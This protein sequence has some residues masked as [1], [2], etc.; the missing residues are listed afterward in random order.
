[1]LVHV[2][3]QTYYTVLFRDIKMVIIVAW[4]FFMCTELSARDCTCSR[5]IPTR[6]RSW[7]IENTGYYQVEICFCRIRRQECTCSRVHILLVACHGTLK[8]LS[9]GDLLG[10]NSTSGVHVLACTNSTRCRSWDTENS[11]Y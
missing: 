3:T 1:M 7:D 10:Q 9:L 5:A 2:L 4:I 11:E 8:I 6:Y